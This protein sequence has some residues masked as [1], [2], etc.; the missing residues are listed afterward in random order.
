M[1]YKR[2]RDEWYKQCEGVLLEHLRKATVLRSMRDIP[3]GQ[4]KNFR[5]AFGQATRALDM[6]YGEADIQPAMYADMTRRIA[7][8]VSQQYCDMFATALRRVDL[9]ASMPNPS[10]RAGHPIHQRV[11]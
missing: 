2:F 9:D 1:L 6:T 11:G 4:R 5:E 10:Q 8:G 3:E 7:G